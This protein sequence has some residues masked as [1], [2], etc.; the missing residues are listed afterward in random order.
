VAIQ[1]ETL[2][3]LHEV[4]KIAAI[5]G[6]DLLFVGPTDLSQAMGHVGQLGHA[7]VW[8]GFAKVSAA[9]KKH[10]KYWGTVPADA[11]Y[12]DRCIEL[13]CQMLILGSDVLCLR[14][15][16]EAI[17]TA[18]GNAFKPGAGEEAG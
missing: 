9:C 8:D 18:Y 7:D 17:Q 11:P 14:R 13:G 5:D 6:V 12:A 4:E 10:G 3:A 16:L 1:I 2:G 15:G